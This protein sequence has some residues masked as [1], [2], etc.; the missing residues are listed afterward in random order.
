MGCGRMMQLN[1]YLV[2][3][4][5]YGAHT[6]CPS[7]DVTHVLYEFTE[8]MAKETLSHE[9]FSSITAVVSS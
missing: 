5:A 6:P 7:L 3:L 1:T 2:A 9:C 4:V 8:F